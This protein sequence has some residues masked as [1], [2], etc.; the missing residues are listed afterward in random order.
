MQLRAR[1]AEPTIFEFDGVFSDSSPQSEVF[2]V[3]GE[4]M[5]AAV[6]TGE[7]AAVISYG[8]SGTGKTHTLFGDL[9]GGAHEAG[10]V[11]RILRALWSRLPSPVAVRMSLLR[12]A[13]DVSVRLTS[14]ELSPFD[15][16]CHDHCRLLKMCLVTRAMTGS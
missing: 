5:L 1:T 7:S 16:A 11:P 12:V 10:L 9:H 15:E 8:A 4:P 13:R 2:S 6:L 3:V 14:A